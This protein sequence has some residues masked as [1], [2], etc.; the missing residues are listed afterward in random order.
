MHVIW[1]VQE[2][3]EG[4]RLSGTHT[5]LL[6]YGD[7]LSLLDETYFLSVWENKKVL[8]ALKI[9]HWT[10]FFFGSFL[11]PNTEPVIDLVLIMAIN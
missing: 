5:N 10:F 1:K 3:D 4:F 7:D 2:D 6:V 8:V 11:I 9:K